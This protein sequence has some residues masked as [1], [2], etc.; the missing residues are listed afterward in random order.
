MFLRPLSLKGPLEGIPGHKPIRPSDIVLCH[1]SFSPIED[2]AS[3]R[4]SDTVQRNILASPAEMK[5]GKRDAQTIK[6]WCTGKKPGKGLPWGG[7]VKRKWL[8]SVLLHRG[9]WAFPMLHTQDIICAPGRGS[10]Q[11][12]RGAIF[13][14]QARRAFL[15]SAPHTAPTAG[16]TSGSRVLS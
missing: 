15:Y 7:P 13:A 10:S 4:L 2:S 16:S 12:G 11:R 8:L 3:R 5:R 14:W 1:V 6:P 9:L